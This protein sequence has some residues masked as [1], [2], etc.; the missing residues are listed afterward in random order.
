MSRNLNLIGSRRLLLAQSPKSRPPYTDFARTAALPVGAWQIALAASRRRP[1]S[2]I[3]LWLPRTAYDWTVAPTRYLCKRMAEQ[4]LN[5]SAS[6]RAGFRAFKIPRT[7]LSTHENIFG[8]RLLG[9]V[10][11]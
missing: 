3:S 6:L 4:D 1:K 5:S 9:K 2:K 10:K 7:L 8:S 11:Q